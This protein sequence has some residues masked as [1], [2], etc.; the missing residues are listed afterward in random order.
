MNT[1]GDMEKTDVCK[2]YTKQV[3]ASLE[4][5]FLDNNGPVS[6]C[7]REAQIWVMLISNVSGTSHF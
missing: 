7:Q 5:K 6:S 2:L 3:V 1:D 4:S